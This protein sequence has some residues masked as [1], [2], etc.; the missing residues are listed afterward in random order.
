[1]SVMGRAERAHGDVAADL[2][3]DVNERATGWMQKGICNH[4]IWN[5]SPKL[6]EALSRG[7]KYFLYKGTLIGRAVDRNPSS[8]S[9]EVRPFLTRPQAQ[10][11]Q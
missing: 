1:M 8:A 5:R 10:D 2:D 3:G 4:G 9:Q 6:A 11:V 7:E